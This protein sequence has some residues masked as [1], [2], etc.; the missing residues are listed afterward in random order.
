MNAVTE[1]IDLKLIQEVDN[2]S[3]VH[4]SLL[5]NGTSLKFFT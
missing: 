1:K 2:D 4:V 5:I 3:S